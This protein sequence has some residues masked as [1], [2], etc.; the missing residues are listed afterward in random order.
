LCAYDTRAAAT[1][2][3][4][5]G[6]RISQGNLLVRHSLRLIFDRIKFHHL[7]FEHHHLFLQALNFSFGK[8]SQL[9]TIR[10]FQGEEIAFD[11][12]FDLFSSVLDLIRREVIVA[13]VDRFEFT[14]IDRYGRFGQ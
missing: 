4:R 1:G 5:A 14:A 6:I 3:H 11:T 13:V 8:I 10:R 7:L 12:G 9:L 2:R